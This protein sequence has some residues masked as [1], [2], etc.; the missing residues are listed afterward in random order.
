P[1][2]LPVIVR[3]CSTRLIGALRRFGPRPATCP[4]PR[5]KSPHEAVRHAA[6]NDRPPRRLVALPRRE[7]RPAHPALLRFGLETPRPSLQ[8][9]HVA[10]TAELP[11][12]RCSPL[13][14]RRPDTRGP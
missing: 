2:P 9:E 3:R 7:N 1:P 6:P 11:A 14:S 5:A 4:R 13:A 12:D 10:A 8:S